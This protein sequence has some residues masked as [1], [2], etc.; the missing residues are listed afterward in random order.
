MN[1]VFWKTQKQS[2]FLHR[3]SISGILQTKADNN[4]DVLLENLMKHNMRWWVKTRV[5]NIFQQIHRYADRY[6]SFSPILSQL[7]R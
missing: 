1:R 6:M 5:A 7:M 2:V 4:Y 3:F